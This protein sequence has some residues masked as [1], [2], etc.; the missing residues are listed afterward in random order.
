MHGLE[1]ENNKITEG[2]HQINIENVP[3]GTYILRVQNHH[4]AQNFKIEKINK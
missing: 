3:V 1:I 2:I 4:Q